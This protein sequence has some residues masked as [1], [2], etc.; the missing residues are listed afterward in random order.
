MPGVLRAHDVLAKLDIDT[1]VGGHVHRLGTPKD[2]RDSRDFTYDLWNTTNRV[3]GRTRLAD[4]TSQ[5]E[6]GNSWAGFQL[7]YDAIADQ[8]E[9][10]IVQRWADKLGGVDVFTRDNVVTIA[11]SLLLDAPK[12]IN[13]PAPRRPAPPRRSGAGTRSRGASGHRVRRVGR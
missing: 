11:V 12:D 3:V 10:E 5:V 9:P 7:Y 8:V 6:P 2:I 1:F 13:C 4:Y